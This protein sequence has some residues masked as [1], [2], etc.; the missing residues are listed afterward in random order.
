MA[1]GRRAAAARRAPT[2]AAINT[3]ATTEASSTRQS[4][5]TIKPTVSA[6]ASHMPFFIRRNSNNKEEKEQQ[7]DDDKTE[8]LQGQESDDGETD[9][10]ISSASLTKPQEE[11]EESTPMSSAL[12]DEGIKEKK[13]VDEH[14]K[15][16][17]KSSLPMIVKEPSVQEEEEPS[18]TTTNNDIG[19]PD[20]PRREP[21]HRMTST[22][23]QDLEGQ[24]Q[25]PTV[26][27]QDAS[28][29]LPLN[30][31]PAAQDK[32]GKD[33][34]LKDG[35]SPSSS[36]PTLTETPTTG[37]DIYDGVIGNEDKKQFTNHSP[38]LDASN[39]K[40][41]GNDQ[42]P[43]TTTTSIQESEPVISCQTQT[44]GP[45]MNV[46]K[47]SLLDPTKGN[48]GRE[49]DQEKSKELLFLGPAS[50][51]H[52]KEERN[53]K[54][55]KDSNG[56]TAPDSMV[57]T[58][59]DE[60]AT[61]GDNTTG[62]SHYTPKE[63]LDSAPAPLDKLNDSLAHIDSLG[64]QEGSSSTTTTCDVDNN[65]HV[66]SDPIATKRQV[67]EGS[68][69][70]DENVDIKVKVND[71][72]D[73]SKDADTDTKDPLV[74]VSPL[75]PQI[76][77]GE[78]RALP[79]RT[80]SSSAAVENV[81]VKN[82]TD[83]QDAMEVSNDSNKR[84]RVDDEVVQP[85]K[86]EDD[87]HIQVVKP[88]REQSLEETLPPSHTRSGE[89]EKVTD[90]LG[91][92]GELSDRDSCDEPVSKRQRLDT[93]DP[94]EEGKYAIPLENATL[95]DVARISHAT[96]DGIPLKGASQ[97]DKKLAGKQ[98]PDRPLPFP[99]VRVEKYEEQQHVAID[100]PVSSLEKA[101]V[102]NQPNDAKN[103][104]NPFI[105]SN[106]GADS[107]IPLN[108]GDSIA[109]DRNTVLT[110]QEYLDIA[111][112]M[113]V[114]ESHVVKNSARIESPTPVDDDDPME[115]SPKEDKSET[116]L[117]NM[118]ETSTEIKEDSN[119]EHIVDPGNEEQLERMKEFASLH[120]SVSQIKT[121]IFLA[122]SKVNGGRGAEKRFIAYWDAL[123][124]YICYGTHGKRL[125][126][127][128]ICRMG[129]SA[130][131]IEKTLKS[132]LVTKKLRQLHNK[133]I[134]AL[135]RN[136]MI[137]TPP[138]GHVHSHIPVQW[139]SKVRQKSIVVCPSPQI[140]EPPSEIVAIPR[141]YSY[142]SI[143]AE[144][145]LERCKSDFGIDSG[146][147]TYSGA[148]CPIFPRSSNQVPFS[149]AEYAQKKKSQSTNRLENL[150]SPRL[151]GALA[152]NP[153]VQKMSS[154]EGMS[155][156]DSAL[157]LLVVAA[158]EYTT[159]VL[160]SAVADVAS[161]CPETGKN[162]KKPKSKKRNSTT[163]RGTPPNRRVIT[164]LDLAQVLA[165]NQK[166]G[167]GTLSSR[168]AVERCIANAGVG[169][170]I[171][172]PS[173]LG[174]IQGYINK[175]I[176]QAASKYQEI[177]NNGGQIGILGKG[178]M[179]YAHSSRDTGRVVRSASPGQGR[180]GK[181]LSSLKKRTTASSE[182]PT[183]GPGVS[184]V[185]SDLTESRSQASSVPAGRGRGRG[186]KNLAAMRARSLTSLGDFKDE[187]KHI[188]AQS[189][190]TPSPDEKINATK[191]K[192]TV[193]SNEEKTTDQDSK[194]SLP[195]TSAEASSKG[196]GGKQL[197]M[198]R[199]AEERRKAQVDQTLVTDRASLPTSETPQSE[200]PKM[201]DQ[202][203]S[204][205]G[206][207]LPV[208]V[209]ISDRKTYEGT[210]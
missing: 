59:K 99:S 112:P 135:M 1:R 23:S 60:T 148:D 172:P 146:V 4:K 41:A 54:M 18:S 94:N 189:G 26:L 77:G 12:P 170:Q 84:E 164:A 51:Q 110:S 194:N 196:I 149:L 140:K 154:A 207:V 70:T 65:A 129:G 87:A 38:S 85:T 34:S 123:G 130:F 63:A 141:K 22:P 75:L 33:A 177:L 115:L 175:E 122:A 71:N 30:G 98:L 8:P 101:E 144:S 210:T 139:K 180:G 17:D 200:S 152:I 74:N 178:E 7:Q 120:T 28:S 198:L 181:D 97:S 185:V 108:S 6:G 118:S 116:N 188:R 114:E 57:V 64:K 184:V 3:S 156:S 145:V 202:N 90:R 205:T 138:L 168:L 81:A 153:L 103:P 111:I 92:N 43:N 100:S 167:G 179:R 191:E 40:D 2:A 158:R 124:Q 195:M 14:V 20:H 52:V 36:D 69:D 133:L 171:E 150:P 147:W 173:G 166:L 5:R 15:I 121:R 192:V 91:Q 136:S 161:I 89:K 39:H 105:G 197:I 79:K 11:E 16:R 53:E 174:A 48:P 25:T 37:Q 31:V 143:K 50:K 187:D 201:L 159:L 61:A 13:E 109:T 182:R 80:E 169:V 142:R 35:P 176:H 47:E 27:S 83:A 95:Q 190:E 88:V 102:T 155:V 82:G 29:S 127:V 62:V 208:P 32:K 151:P 76:D 107:S 104:A 49:A 125:D 10:Q 117:M 46:Q 67:S 165:R 157:W 199:A 209:S 58:E 24:S 86:L 19:V 9:E 55:S 72:V 162:A 137:E 128:N 193:P 66:W 119:N 56:D 206:D 42:S 106:A 78:I 204:R 113:D 44:S 21:L 73:S 132:F 93:V 96:H 186:S 163:N 68:A 160:K 126:N 131:Y 183:E 134:L 45:T 203:G